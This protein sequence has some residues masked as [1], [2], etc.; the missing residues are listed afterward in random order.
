MRMLQ[1]LIEFLILG[2]EG[3]DESAASPTSIKKEKTA[4]IKK[5]SDQP[6]IPPKL[7]V[8][9]K[10]NLQQSD[11]FLAAFGDGVKSV[12]A[13]KK[14]KVNKVTK[15]VQPNVPVG[16]ETTT[17]IKSECDVSLKYKF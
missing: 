9:P 1:L 4:P 8:P 13:P 17:S 10:R 15:V 3:D 16:A 11:M 14:L 12:P 5:K 6:T 7:T 2:L